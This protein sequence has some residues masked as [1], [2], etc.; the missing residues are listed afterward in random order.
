MNRPEL[1]VDVVVVL[2]NESLVVIE[3]LS[4]P[5]GLALPGGHVENGELLRESAG[6]ELTEET[7]LTAQEFELIGIYDEPE[8]DPR[9]HKISCAFVARN[10]S[11]TVK[12]EED[13][14]RVKIIPIAELDQ[15]STSFVCDH[16]KIIN[17][18]LSQK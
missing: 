17:D 2:G 1:C 15:H 5:K 8:R 16:Y 12:H 3:R 14:T 7:G 9:S 6:R 18:F 10:V 4:E 11:G 13:K